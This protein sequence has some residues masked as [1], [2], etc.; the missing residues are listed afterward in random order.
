MKG[1]DSTATS[2]AGSRPTLEGRVG[3]ITGA[4]RGIGAATARAF[5]AAGAAVALAAR[6][7]AALAALAEELS[8][9]GGRAIAVPTDVADRASV[10][11]LVDQTVDAFGRLDLAFNNAA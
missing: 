2:M 10:E 6:D 5:V 1:V 4:S 11:R 8:S 7:G 9:D 3:I